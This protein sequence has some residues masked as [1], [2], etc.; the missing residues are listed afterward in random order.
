V[1]VALAIAISDALEGSLADERRIDV[2]F[3]DPLVHA[4]VANAA[5][6]RS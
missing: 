4:F 3:V 6:T 1:I 2:Q 5:R